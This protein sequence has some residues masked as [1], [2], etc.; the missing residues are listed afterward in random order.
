MIVRIIEPIG[1][2]DEAIRSR[3][4]D[5]LEERGHR[6]FICDTRGMTDAE[7]IKNVSDADILLL[8]NRPL[9]RVVIEACPKLKLI[10]VAFT[11]IDHVDQEAC[12]ARGI[13]LHNAAGYAVH[14]VSE[15]AIGLMIVLLR[16]IVSAD[17]TIRAGGTNRKLVGNELFGKTLGV[18]GCG[19]IGLQVARLGNAFGCH[20]LGFEPRV[21]RIDDVTIEQVEIDELLSRSDIVTLHLPLTTE[22][23]GFIG[24][25][26]LGRMKRSAILINTARGPV[27]D[28]S[29]LVEALDQNRLAGAA[30]DVF[31]IEPPL[32]ADH[33]ILKAPNTILVPHIGFETAEAMAAK[34]NIA[35]HHLENFLSGRRP[36]HNRPNVL[37]Q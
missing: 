7:L 12:T 24:R 28:Q 9:S 14:A 26:Q 6:L 35:L 29:A 2:S 33:P 11:G 37:V 19:N 23:L 5:L 36:A 10:C 17:A 13:I 25:E 34:A 20:V 1:Q 16:R 32:P 22:T 31:D 15:L 27:V 3:L 8:S 18:V 21:L 30:L 4:G